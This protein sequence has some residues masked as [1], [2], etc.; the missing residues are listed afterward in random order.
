MGQRYSSVLFFRSGQWP[1]KRVT[2]VLFPTLRPGVADEHY[3]VEISEDERAS[4]VPDAATALDASWWWRDAPGLGFAAAVFAPSANSVVAGDHRGLAL[5]DAYLTAALV[6]LQPEFGYLSIFE[7]HRERGWIERVMAQLQA[8]PPAGLYVDYER[9]LLSAALRAEV[10][11]RRAW[12][13]I[14]EAHGGALAKTPA[15]DD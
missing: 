7:D 12:T 11:W 5:V 6:H 3:R 14:A 4:F 8:R 1:L 13:V 9:V 10:P 15:F 2:T